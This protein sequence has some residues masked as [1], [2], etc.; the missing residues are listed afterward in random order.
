MEDV[1]HYSVAACRSQKL[2]TKT[3][4][5]PRRNQKVQAHVARDILHIFKFGFAATQTFHD[6]AHVILR[7]FDGK[8]FYRFILLP[9]NQFVNDFGLADLHL[10]TFATHRFN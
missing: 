7:N 3:Y 1:I 2:R 4:Q 10:V 5:P 8:I 6:R 9:V